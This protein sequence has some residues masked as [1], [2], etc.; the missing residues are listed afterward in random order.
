MNAIHHFFF[1]SLM[2]STLSSGNKDSFSGYGALTPGLKV[3]DL[4]LLFSIFL[5]C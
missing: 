4:D 5:L 3:S 1:F 2:L